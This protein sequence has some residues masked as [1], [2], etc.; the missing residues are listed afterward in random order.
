MSGDVSSTRRPWPFQAQDMEQQPQVR[1]LMARAFEEGADAMEAAAI[2]AVR[3]H[4]APA[5]FDLRAHLVRQ[6]AFSEKTFGPGA[7]TAGV[8]DHIRKELR[9]IEEHPTDLS[10]WIDVVI[11]AL[12]GAWRAGHS[13]DQII[14]ALQA[15]QAKNEART[16]PD[17]RTAPLDRAIEHVRV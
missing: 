1:S 2:E 11:L 13:P 15:K 6:R 16:W 12:D 8:V 9:E 5:G 14:E 17:W 4:A 10:E 7:S 3:A